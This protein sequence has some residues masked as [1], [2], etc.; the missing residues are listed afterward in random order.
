MSDGSVRVSKCSV[1][2]EYESCRSRRDG[3]SLMNS[4]WV[5]LGVELVKSEVV[6]GVDR[7]SW[8]Y[9]DTVLGLHSGCCGTRMDLESWF[10]EPSRGNQEDRIFPTEREEGLREGG[11]GAPRGA[12]EE[13][14]VTGPDGECGGSAVD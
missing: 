6:D 10:P 3:V 9:G 12:A 5:S 7:S 1:A 14:R 2:S 4:D 11:R 13:S 8:S